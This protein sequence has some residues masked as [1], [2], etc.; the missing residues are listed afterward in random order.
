[1]HTYEL[2]L[3]ASTSQPSERIELI[4]NDASIAFSWAA[5]RA[6]G[7]KFELFEDGRSLGRAA[8]SHGANVWILSPASGRPAGPLASP[9][10]P[11]TAIP[12]GE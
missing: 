6:Y 3:E 8:L 12:L 7:R 1:M 4:A 9:P 2:V 10:E 11:L 5:R